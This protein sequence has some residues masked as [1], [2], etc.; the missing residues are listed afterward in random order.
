MTWRAHPHAVRVAQLVVRASVSYGPM[1]TSPISSSAPGEIDVEDTR[2]MAM[3][4]DPVRGGLFELVRRARSGVSIA[5]LAKTSGLSASTV[6]DLVDSLLEI[7]LLRRIRA[8]GTRT[9]RFAATC[10]Q[11]TIIA[12]PN[13]PEHV[14]SVHA[15][16]RAATADIAD[17]LGDAMRMTGPLADHQRRIDARVKLDLRPE[18]WQEFLRRIRSVYDYLDDIAATR[19]GKAHAGPHGCDHVLSI[20]LAPTVKPLLP[21]PSIRVAS[22]SR[23]CVAAQPQAKHALL[24]LRERQVA[25]LV[26]SGMR[27][28]EIAAKVGISVNTIATLLAR[29]YRKLDVRSRKSLKQRLARTW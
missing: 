19:R 29:A 14:A 11:I 5:E 17:A 25:T 26:A 6:T 1:A 9:N 21:S 20:Q 3:L 13:R 4:G 16:F 10:E 28:K 15:H 24:T 8:R 22:R 12:D 27:R 23:L 18:E 2:V 7:G